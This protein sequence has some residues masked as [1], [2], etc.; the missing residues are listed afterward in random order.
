M[1]ELDMIAQSTNGMANNIGT[2]VGVAI[3]VLLGRESIVY[4]KGR[5]S[6]KNGTS[7]CVTPVECEKN[8]SHM[9]A[10]A[11]QEKQAAEKLEEARHEEILR[12]LEGTNTALGKLHERVDKLVDSKG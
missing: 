11:K 8:M 12:A 6:K 7:K 2:A 3:T 4:G 9:V 1:I 5:I 10:M